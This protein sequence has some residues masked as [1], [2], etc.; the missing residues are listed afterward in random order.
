[1]RRKRGRG[2]GQSF[3]LERP[4]ALLDTTIDGAVLECGVFQY[5][6]LMAVDR[7]LRHE[8]RTRRLHE[9]RTLPRLTLEF[10]DA[11]RVHL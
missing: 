8:R 2:R 1:V 11:V 7:G 9:L 3:V 5:G 6:A 10:L 4:N